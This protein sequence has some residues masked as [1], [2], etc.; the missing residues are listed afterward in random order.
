[1]KGSVSAL[2]IP[3]RAV[4]ASWVKTDKE[5]WEAFYKNYKLTIFE[6][7]N[8][9]LVWQYPQEFKEALLRIIAETS[10]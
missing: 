6:N 4:N 7:A 8:H 3:I 1:M 2:T 9:F 10:S 5:Q